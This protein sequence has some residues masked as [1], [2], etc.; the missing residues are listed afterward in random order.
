MAAAISGVRDR[1]NLA[2]LLTY[3][4]KE[5]SFRTQVNGKTG[6]F[7]DVAMDEEHNLK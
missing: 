4:K 6:T 2:Q 3:E 7:L 5:Y 1:N